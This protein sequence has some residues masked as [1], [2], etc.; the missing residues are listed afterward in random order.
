MKTIGIIGGM[1]WESTQV[2]YRL[3]N[4]MVRDRLGKLNSAEIIL[5]SL[6]FAPVEVMQKENR[7]DDAGQLLGEHAKKLELGGA[8]FV[9]LATN[10][11][12]RV[13]DQIQQAISI[14]LL[15]I[16]DAVG[17]SLT[18]QNIHHAGLLGT[19]FTMEQPFLKERLAQYGVDI[20][21]PADND[22]HK[23]HR[24]IFDELCQGQFKQQSRLGYLAI[25]NHLIAQGAEA[26]VAG[27]T[28][29]GLLINQQDMSVP[30]LDTSEIHARAA[31]ELALD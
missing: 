28:E 4:Q 8:D 31:V 25:V 24:I 13:A 15:H 16:A 10:T 7:W 6:N 18:S 23:V 21:I 1:S 26:I 27:C 20:L 9:V 14:P 12:H 17:D 22:R 5:S 30:F 2:Y 3:I 29:I 19:M 11:M